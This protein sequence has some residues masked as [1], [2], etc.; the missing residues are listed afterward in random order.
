[1]SAASGS[2]GA[3]ESPRGLQALRDTISPQS[4]PE[5]LVGDKK[6]ARLIRGRS[7]LLTLCLKAG[8]RRLGRM[9][10][11]LPERAFLAGQRRCS[12]VPTRFPA[13]ALIRGECSREMLERTFGAS[14]SKSLRA[15]S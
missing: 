8:V 10:A 11:R 4:C 12:H 1:M 2:S 15:A 5:S 13:R 6:L 7:T 3:A 9:L 14:R